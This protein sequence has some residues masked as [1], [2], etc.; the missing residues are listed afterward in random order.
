MQQK[1]ITGGTGETFDQLGILNVHS[2][3]HEK[4]P[5]CMED[6]V[7]LQYSSATVPK[8]SIF[9]TLPNFLLP[10]LLRFLGM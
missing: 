2:W 8:G 7:A 9:R 3:T 10:A 6:I 5:H 4:H 1:D